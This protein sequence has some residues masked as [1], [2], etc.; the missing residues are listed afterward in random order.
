MR[1]LAAAVRYGVGRA[2]DNTH[3]PRVR[4]EASYCGSYLTSLPT[5]V[6]SLGCYMRNRSRQSTAHVFV[7]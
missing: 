4:L 2:D 6:G 7:E 5:N 3:R 1:I